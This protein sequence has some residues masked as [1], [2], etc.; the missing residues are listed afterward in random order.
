MDSFIPKE[1]LLQVKENNIKDRLTKDK[2]MAMEHID[3]PME[4]ST[5]DSLLKMRLK[6][7]EDT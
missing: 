7:M 6:E 3:L 4:M 2:C 1:I 5:R